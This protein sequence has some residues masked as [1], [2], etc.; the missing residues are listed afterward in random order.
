MTKEKRN[1]RDNE[2]DTSFGAHSVQVRYKKMTNTKHKEEK[3]V[4]L[5]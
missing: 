2:G 4:L 1:D 3:Y 5:C